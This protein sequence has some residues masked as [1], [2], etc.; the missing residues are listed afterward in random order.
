MKPEELVPLFFSLFYAKPVQLYGR[1]KFLFRRRFLRVTASKSLSKRAHELLAQLTPVSEFRCTALNRV[2]HYGWDELTWEDRRQEKLWRYTLNY[3]YWLPERP[4]E[5]GAALVLHWI[6]HNDDEGREP[7]EP[8]AI[9]HRMSQ[10]IDWAE[11][12]RDE[13]DA[14]PGFQELLE[15]SLMAQLLRLSVDLEF[16]VQANHLLENYKALFTA[17]LYLCHRCGRSG[18]CGCSG[19]E[20]DRHLAASID[21]FLSQLNEQILPDGGHYER[22]P[23]YHCLALQAVKE[24]KAGAVEAGAAEAGAVETGAVET[25][26]VKAG[27]VETGAVRAGAVEAADAVQAGDVQ[28]SV[29]KAD[30]SAAIAAG[31]RTTD[32]RKLQEVTE[33]KMATLYEHC[34]S[35]LPKMEEWRSFMTHPDGAM[36]LFGDSALNAYPFIDEKLP[37]QVNDAVHHMTDSGYE[38]RR[39]GDGNYFVMKLCGPSPAWQPGHSHCDTLSFELSLQ[40]ERVVV[41]S[42]C[43]SYQNPAI[44]RY[45]RGTG[46][47]NVA[48]IEG[49]EQSE[50]GGA[51][52]I[53]RRAIVRSCVV[54]VESDSVAIT[55][56]LE[57]YKGNRIQRKATLTKEKLSVED[58]LMR[59]RTGG[60]FLSLIH[61]APSV[62]ITGKDN[63]TVN[64]SGK[65]VRFSLTARSPLAVNPSKY[66]P[67]FGL[68]MEN[69]CIAISGGEDS[70]IEYTIAFQESR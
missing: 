34:R 66:Y 37:G 44:R 40:G 20:T 55:A 3:F 27:A 58:R 41:D 54:T 28:A 65:N 1:L 38:I 31:R 16:H 49:N 9:S 57:D 14:V 12:H 19:K 69:H 43:G 53:G 56:L 24:V 52:R 21:G 64:L 61:L 5:E 4:F 25:G 8:A 7:W 30:A 35:L 29:A 22:S 13:I 23:L 10:W 59:R 36:A 68:E 32:E 50:C 26:A 67:E 51:F 63:Q 48:W 15:D 45:C 17:S 70:V 42:G 62:D 60:D 2:A 47:H 18:C 11:K 46:A 39:W 6:A 33:G